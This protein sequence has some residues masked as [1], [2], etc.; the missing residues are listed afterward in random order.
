MAA[1]P[2]AGSPVP[3]PHPGLRGQLRARSNLAHLPD[4]LPGDHFSEAGLH[5]A[6]AY[7]LIH[8]HLLLDGNAR[9]NLATFVGTW[10]EPEARRLLEECGD[11]NI[12]DKDEYPQTTDLEQRCLRMLADLWHAPDPADAV[13]ASTTGSSEGCM[14]AGLVLRWHW[15][16]RRGLGAGTGRPNLVMGANRQVCWDKFCAYFDVEPRFI[17]LRDD[18]LHLDPAGAVA[19]CDANTIGVVAVLGSVLDGSYEPVAAIAAALEA[20][21]A[22][23]GLVV[24]LHVDAASGGF[25]APFLA[26]DLV[27]DFRLERVWSINASGHKYGG[28]LPGVGW[29]LWR[30]DA[31]LP[32]EL[33][34]DVNYLGG[35]TPTIGM[36]FS[37]P[38]AQVVGQYFNFIHLG[39]RGYRH[40][41]QALEAIACHLADGIAAI[42]PLRLVSH[43]RG[44]L[45]VFCVE[46]EGPTGHWSVFHLSDK[47]RERGWLVPAYTLPPDQQQR[48]VLRFVVRAGFTRPLADELLADLRRAVTWFESLRAPMPEP[49]TH[50]AF[51][52]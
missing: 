10:M 12:I 49:M 7:E 32:A 5:P 38:G 51:R 30:R 45:P 31:L 8:A 24:P 21:E 37:R 9:L 36:N 40:R 20:L 47:L 15:R 35:V 6:L 19:A 18:C 42:A 26:P 14:L 34:F 1:R 41:L 25:V 23:S 50:T 22:R 2:Q 52:H 48:A 4:H 43:P 29:V 13:G 27:W 11:K 46:R 16:Q 44:Q 39:R 3:E 33:R 17:P 28:V